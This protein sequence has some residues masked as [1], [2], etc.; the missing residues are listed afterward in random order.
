MK[1]FRTGIVLFIIVLFS[2]SYAS[3]DC[4]SAEELSRL[5]F[6]LINLN[7]EEITSYL[8]MKKQAD[9]DTIFYRYKEN[10]L[11]S[12][13]ENLNTLNETTDEYESLDPY[14]QNSIYMN[15][16]NNKE[17][18][19]INNTDSVIIN[20]YNKGI[21]NKS[22]K[23]CYIAQYFNK[24]NLIFKQRK[25]QIIDTVEILYFEKCEKEITTN[26][27]VL[28]EGDI[29]AVIV[30]VKKVI[31]AT[32]R[33]FKVYFE[34][35]ECINR[36]AKTYAEAIKILD[37]FENSDQNSKRENINR[38]KLRKELFSFQNAGEMAN[39]FYN[40]FYNS[41][42]YDKEAIL[43]YLIARKYK[44]DF[45]DG[46]KKELRENWGLAKQMYQMKKY[47]EAQN[48]VLYC[49]NDA[50][51]LPAFKGLYDSLCYLNEEL[52]GLI[53]DAK[54]KRS[55]WTST[56]SINKSLQ[57]SVGTG[58]CYNPSLMDFHWKLYTG[59]SQDELQVPIYKLRGTFS[60]EFSAVFGY[61]M[62]PK[63]V[64]GISAEYSKVKYN[65]VRFSNSDEI[66]NVTGIEAE[67]LID[68]VVE[69]FS[70]Q[71]FGKYYFRTSPGFMPYGKL[72]FGIIQ[73]SRE[74]DQY[75]ATKFFWNPPYPSYY[76]DYYLEKKEATG[77]QVIP[78]FGL[79]FL[80]TAES[81]VVYTI[82]LQ[83][84]IMTGGVNEMLGH[85]RGQAGLRI[86]LTW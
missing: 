3:D 51:D 17:N 46:R 77:F 57:I 2:I 67:T 76:L 65:E 18:F 79:D 38:L 14:L 35:I 32:D 10:F 66:S 39:K 63:F 16:V 26:D 9:F 41:M 42:L 61:Y 5:E 82:Y 69:Y 74:P 25:S 48:L 40:R 71:I 80:K 19:R 54:Y 55:L 11:K 47:D 4:L 34:K 49:K 83:S 33:K 68:Y 73:I 7:T 22:A 62:S 56:E 8:K 37:D 84:A 15:F 43:Y 86:T 1:S 78:E 45:I 12:E 20:I 75:M 44:Q 52:D 53:E 58:L 70:A 28:A 13:L 23:L 50:P 59:D 31:A 64:I 60:P 29:V 21:T 6:L 81:T 72:G 30:Q 24:R 36:L 85:F 27:S